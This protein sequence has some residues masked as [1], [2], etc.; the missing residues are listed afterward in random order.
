MTGCEILYVLV[1]TSASEPQ[2]R[3]QQSPS[4]CLQQGSWLLSH[5]DRFWFMILI[6]Y[7]RTSWIGVVMLH[8]L[9]KLAS[10]TEAVGIFG[11][12]HHVIEEL[13]T[14]LHSFFNFSITQAQSN[15]DHP[16]LPILRL[17]S[18]VLKQAKFVLTQLSDCVPL[19]LH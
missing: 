15:I 2:L 18:E 12:V 11:R 13:K 17:Q 4:P 19:Y 8:G 7:A 9:L 10:R 5:Y 1:P 14:V 6:I 3:T 16:Q